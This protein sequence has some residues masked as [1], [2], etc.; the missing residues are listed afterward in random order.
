MN[1]EQGKSLIKLAHDSIESFLNN[2]TLKVDSQ[3]KEMFSEK[4]GA[5]VTLKKNG[6]LRGCI[7]YVEPIFELWTTII[8]AARSAAFEDPRFI[9][10]SKKE[11]RDIKI[12]V[13]VLTLPQKIIVKDYVEYYSKIKIGED[14]LIVKRGNRSG[15]LLPQVATEYNMDVVEFLEHTCLKAGLRKDAYKE[16]DC[17]VYKFQAEIFSE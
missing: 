6:E 14:G 8:R 1:S 3:L 2:E 16:H 5:F 9:P 7:G 4:R 10:L 15:L 11:Y 17:E 12:E 13:S